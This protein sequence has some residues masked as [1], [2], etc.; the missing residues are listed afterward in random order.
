MRFFIV[1]Y[2]H[3]ARWQGFAGATVKILDLAENLRRMGASVVLFVPKCRL[4]RASI[5]CQVVET[6]YVDLPVLRVITF[7]LLLFQSLW[8]EGRKRQA[9]ILYLRRTLTLTPRIYAMMAGCR[10]FYEVNDDPYRNLYVRSGDLAA[11]MRQWFSE[12]VDGWHL[13][14]ADRIFV[15][16]ETVQ[17]K[18]QERNPSIPAERFILQ[19]SGA[20]TDLFIP[21]PRKEAFAHL[22]LDPSMRYVGF[23]G[24]LLRH[25]GVQHLIRSAR[26]VLVHCPDI[27]FLIVGEGP[28]KEDWQRMTQDEGV[29][30]AFVFTGQVAYRELPR[31]INAMDV[32]VAPYH[33]KAGYRSPV[34]IFD[35]LA[36]GRPVVASRI[37][38][39]TDAFTNLSAVSLVP[40]E[41]E[42]ALAAAIC[43]MLDRPAYIET[44]GRQG[45][46]WVVR[47]FSR[48][49]MAGRVWQTAGKEKRAV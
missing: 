30:H 41:D 36:C 44:I 26:H 47:Q 38:G 3:D 2:W 21:M 29:S 22:P 16:S 14:H 27:R 7:N 35:Y 9:D 33:K 43:H 48:A 34:K 10:F 18:I 39:T 49:D 4:D 37:A 20:N 12:I 32:C 17:R 42:N 23:V 24:S 5:A 15:I 13:R 8:L 28:M 6:P 25:Q 1:G 40:P 11:R 46:Q 31:W 19:P 45:R